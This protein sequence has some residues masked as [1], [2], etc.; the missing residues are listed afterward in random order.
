MS[1]TVRL[2]AVIRRENDAYVSLCPELDIASHGDSVDEARAMLIEA[3]QGWFETAS[4][5]EVARSI[6]SM[7]R[8][9]QLDLVVP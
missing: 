9:E 6:P 2:T 5:D 1:K 7:I 3:V 8:I 4:E